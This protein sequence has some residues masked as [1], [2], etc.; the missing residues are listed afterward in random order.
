MKKNNCDHDWIYNRNV[1]P[2]KRKCELCNRVETR[3]V[4]WD[5]YGLSPTIIT[6]WL[7]VDTT[8]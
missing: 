5:Y 6:E 3:E 7:R 1:L 8:I 2:S 4:S